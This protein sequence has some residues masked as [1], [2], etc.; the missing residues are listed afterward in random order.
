[1]AKKSISDLGDQ[2]KKRKNQSP[3]KYRFYFWHLIS[4]L[5]I[6]YPKNDQLEKT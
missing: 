4:Q 3:S 2:L 5:P 1:M 6:F